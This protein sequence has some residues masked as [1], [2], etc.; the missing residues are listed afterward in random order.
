MLSDAIF[1]KQ[2]APITRKLASGVLTLLSALAIALGL[3]GCDGGQPAA[4]DS[5][6]TPHA[7][8]YPYSVVTTVGMITDIVQNVAGDKAKVEGLMGTGVDPHLYKP[9]RRDISELQKADIVFYNGLMLEGKMADVL[10]QIARRG[11]PVYAVTEA[12]LESEDYVMETPQAHYDPHVWD[13]RGRVDRGHPASR[14]GP[15][16]VRSAQRRLLHPQRRRLH[17]P[18]WSDWMPT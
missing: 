16:Q 18:G 3:A 2:T 4:A 1:P 5:G 13:G 7:S 6:E 14:P 12:I 9:T 17:H 15:R 8:Q 10:M 11:K